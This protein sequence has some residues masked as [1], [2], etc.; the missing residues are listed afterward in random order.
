MDKTKALRQAKLE[1]IK[2]AKEIMRHPVFW[3]PFIQMGDSSSI[4]IS[5]KRGI[6][7][8]LIAGGVLILLIG[9]L[10]LRR[11]KSLV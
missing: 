3:S 9:G 2:S 5:K 4:T 11:R 8:W 7:P 1:Y 10:L 6:L